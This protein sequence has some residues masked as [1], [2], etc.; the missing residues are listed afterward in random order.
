MSPTQEA[1]VSTP[2]TNYWLDLFTGKTWREFQAVGSKVSGFREHNWKRAAAIKPGDVFLCYLVGVKRW[3]GV[4]EVAGERYKD[5]APIFE[6]EVFPVRF[7][8]VP[9]VLLSPEHGIPMETFAGKLSFYHLDGTGH[10]SGLVRSSPTKYDPADG[11]LIAAAIREAAANPGPPRPVDPKQ[12]ER[13]PNLYKLRTK[14]GNEEIEAVVSV[15]TTDEEDVSQ[16]E[17]PADGPTHSEIQWRLL[18][19]GSQIG[20]KVWAPKSDRNKTWGNKRIGYVPNLLECL[21]NQFDRVTNKTIENIDV[22]WLAGQTIVGA[23]EVEHTT[24]IYSG[25]LRMSDLITMQPN[26]DIKFYLAAPDERYGKFCDEVARATFASRKK[27]LHTMCRFLPYS[28]LCARLEEAKNF[29]R[30]LRPEFLDE[31]ADL[32]DPAAEIDA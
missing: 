8:V 15:P 18:D 5:D 3:V 2:S 28:K 17:G 1:P 21:P 32:Y 6:D 20:L 19:L 9:H 25:L 23:F 29:M 24:S 12:L 14:A 10:W 31:I 7:P 11:A 4:L 26:L 27:P 13:S 16:E 22:L 30:Y